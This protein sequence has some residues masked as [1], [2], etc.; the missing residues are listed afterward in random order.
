[1]LTEDLLRLI[2]AD[3]AREI[4]AADRARLASRAAIERA[5]ERADRPLGRRL[6]SRVPRQPGTP[7]IDPTL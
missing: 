2:Q 5:E 6:E 3:R 4:A 7:A 1:M